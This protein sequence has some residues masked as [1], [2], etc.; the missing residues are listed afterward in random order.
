MISLSASRRLRTAATLIWP[1]WPRASWIRGSKATSVP[2]SASTDR[3]PA[4]SP[5][6]STRSAMN[7]VSSAIAVETWVPL[8]SARPS[9]GPSTSGSSPSRASASPAGS[10]SPPSRIAPSPI[11]AAARWASGARSPT[12]PPT[13]ARG[14]PARRRHRARRAAAR[15]PPGERRY[16]RARARSPSAP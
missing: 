5:D 3:A 13:P 4:T 6:A 8:I 15:P 2:L 10:R 7:R 11:S 16:G 12:L 9:F 1:G 14:S